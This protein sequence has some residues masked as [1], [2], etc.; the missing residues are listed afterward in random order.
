MTREFIRLNILLQYFVFK[1]M[2]RNSL[3]Y[4]YINMLLS[5]MHSDET[6]AH[7]SGIYFPGNYKVIIS[8]VIDAVLYYIEE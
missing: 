2:N 4:I 7:F 1:N 6:L 5:S 3:S 8:V